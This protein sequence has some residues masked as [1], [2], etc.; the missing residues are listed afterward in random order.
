MRHGFGGLHKRMDVPEQKILKQRF[1]I[2]P[3]APVKPTSENPV[4]DIVA[5]KLAKDARGP[6]AV[7]CG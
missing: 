7:G 1:G 4:P 6:L 3:N 2:Q 5:G